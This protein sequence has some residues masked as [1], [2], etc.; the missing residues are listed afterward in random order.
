MIEYLTG[1][2]FQVSASSNAEN[3]ISYM[4]SNNVDIVITDVSMPNG[5]DGLELTRYIKNRYKISV[6]IMTGYADEYSYE[7]AMDAG[8]IDFM[9][10]PIHFTELMFRINRILEERKTKSELD[11]MIAKLKKLAITDGL[12]GLFNSRHFSNQLTKEL[13]RSNRYDRP[14]SLLLLDV[15]HFKLYNDTYG[16]VEGDEVLCGLGKTINNCLRTMD[17]GYR[18]GGEEFTIILPET[19]I[20]DAS[21][22]AQRI[23]KYLQDYPIPA[24][25]E[26]DITVSIGITEH[27]KDESSINFLKRADKAMYMSK[28]NGRDMITILVKD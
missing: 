11:E 24:N 6:I 12:T 25:K 20:T 13:E 2:Q 10:K 7:K 23:Q 1:Q 8:A 19:N 16:H 15:D 28:Q 5:K 17:S 4:D 3:A 26:R 9:F 22:V 21:L 18:Y 14:V 27:I